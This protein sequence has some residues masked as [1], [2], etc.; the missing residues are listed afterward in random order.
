MS[1]LLQ[2]EIYMLVN[3][4]NIR[5]QK[6]IEQMKDN[7][8]MIIFAGV[9][10]KRSADENYPFVVN[11]NFYYLTG[12][13][14]EN[15][16]LM[17]VKSEGEDKTY[18]FVD[19]RDPLKEKWI[20]KKLSFEEAKELSGISNIIL[21]NSL[22]AKID[23]VLSQS[24]DQYGEISSLYLDLEKELKIDECKSTIDFSKELHEMYNKVDIIDIYP[25]I[26]KLRMIKSPYEIAQLRE[27]IKITESGIQKLLLITKPGLY[28]YNLVNTF[29]YEISDN[30]ASLSFPTICASGD[31]ATTLHYPFASDVISEDS[32]ILLDLGAAHEN[33]CADISR[34]IPASGKFTTLQKTIYNIVL[35]CNKAVINYIKPGLTLLKLQEFTIDFLSAE[36]LSKGLINT[37]EEIKDVY[38]HGVSHCLGLDTHD[39]DLEHRQGLLKPGMVVTVEPGLYFKK[40]GIGVRIEDDVLVTENGSDNLSKDILKDPEDIEHLMA[41]R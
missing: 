16:A 4:L 10:K 11:R 34:T 12:I 7:S 19:E 13:S 33:Y 15:S 30:G 5:R 36:C 3:E 21:T 40:Y 27:A 26:I 6:I 39:P 31:N 14:Q 17:I 8:V 23:A 9:G 1:N 29:L 32:L 35:E 18:L 41:S 38:Y 37:R 2:E 28:E 25:E 20:G 22:P 24:S